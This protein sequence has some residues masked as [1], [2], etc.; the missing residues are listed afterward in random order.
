MDPIILAVILLFLAIVA[1]FI[2]LTKKP[3]KEAHQC[4]I[5]GNVCEDSTVCHDCFERSKIIK[6]ELPQ[7]RIETYE[8]IIQFRQELM[9][10]IAFTKDNGQ[11]ELCCIRLLALSDILKYKYQ[12]NRA[13]ER[14]NQFFKDVESQSSYTVAEK[15][16]LNPESQTFKAGNPASHSDASEQN[17]KKNQHP[18]K[19][20]IAK[21][22]G[23]AFG[24]FLFILALILLILLT[25]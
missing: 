16:G 19:D 24:I 12:E 10:N 18:F 2:A 17:D 11:K 25:R 23:C 1:L 21:G 4:F 3:K 9:S 7:E 6:D 13:F 8:A 22:F 15:Y 5:C 14:T 20:G